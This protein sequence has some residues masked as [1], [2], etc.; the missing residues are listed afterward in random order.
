VSFA[1]DGMFEIWNQSR[2]G[3]EWQYPII[4]TI[5]TPA[6]GHWLKFTFSESNLGTSRFLLSVAFDDYGA[7]GQESPLLLFSGSLMTTNLDAAA[8]NSIFAGFNGWYHVSHYDEF[9]VQHSLDGDLLTLTWCPAN[10]LKP[11]GSPPLSISG[12]HPAV[13]I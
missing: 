9:S 5:S 4:G 10:C 11:V 12:F 8:D 6:S 7:T 2:N 1:N 3:L 13:S